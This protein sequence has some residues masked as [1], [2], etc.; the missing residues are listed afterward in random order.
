MSTAATGVPLVALPLWRNNPVA[1]C[2]DHCSCN[3]GAALSKSP[4]IIDVLDIGTSLG[5]ALAI[6]KG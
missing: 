5:N 6:Q 4:T 3:L 2:L 1:G